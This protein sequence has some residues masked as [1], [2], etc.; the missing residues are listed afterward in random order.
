MNFIELKRFENE[1][2]KTKQ[3]LC[4]TL[5]INTLTMLTLSKRFL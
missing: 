4:N 5:Y 1:R 3:M 2:N